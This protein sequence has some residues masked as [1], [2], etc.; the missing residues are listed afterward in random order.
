MCLLFKGA[1]FGI[2]LGPAPWPGIDGNFESVISVQ[3]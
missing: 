3:V 2:W 1:P